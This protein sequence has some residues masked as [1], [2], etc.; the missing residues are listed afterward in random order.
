MSPARAEPAGP[1]P[2]ARA[3]ARL[4][5]DPDRLAYGLRTA[6]AACLALVAAWTLGLEHPQWAGMTV[7][8]ASQPVRAHLI[9][10]SLFRALGTVAGA[11]YGVLL[12]GLAA[13]SGGPALLVAGVALW[14]GLCAAAGNVLRGFASYG[15]L[16]AG[17]SAAMV[18]L[19]D[20]GHPEDVVGLGLDRTATVLVG[21]AVALLVGL[22]LTPRGAQADLPLRLR[23]ASAELL[24]AIAARLRAPET[25]ADATAGARLLRELA[26]LDDEIDGEGAGSLAARRE[27]R[28]RRQT[29]MA[30]VSAILWLQATPAVAADAELADAIDV[31]AADFAANAPIPQRRTSL[32]RAARRAPGELRR[33][34]AGLGSALPRGTGEPAPDRRPEPLRLHRD[35][36]AAREAA[37]RAAGTIL[38]VGAVWVATG[39]WAGPLMMLGAAILTSVFSTMEAPLSLLPRVAAG[40]ALGVAAALACR[41]LVWPHAGSEAALVLSTL[42]FVLAGGVVMGHPRLQVQAFDANMV[43]LLLLQPVW[44]LAGSLGHSLVSGVAVVSGP[45]IAMLAFRFVHPPSAARRRDALLRTLVGEVEAMASRPG[46][47]ARVTAWRARLHHRLL[48]LVRWT[49]RAGLD[50]AEAAAGGIALVRL[51][52]AVIGLEAR[53]A[54]GGLPVAER[55]ALVLALARAARVGAEPERAARDLEAVARLGGRE[56]PLFL[57][58]AEA[59]R[60]TAGLLAAAGPPST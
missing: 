31:I 14:L 39:W 56:A 21:V 10:K 48:R 49:D 27:A 4:G 35:W 22:A 29:L 12:A 51:G 44:P 16:L 58:A 55:Q 33:V 23:Q 28:H 11:I 57:A 46:A 24:A 8:A 32:A 54:E 18:A 15:A 47:R 37:V 13:R 5:L 53:L 26:A 17:Y 45:V 34:L 2:V 41:W 6:L 9:E 42:P 50:T 30:Q 60:R 38:L 19:L 25:P 40:Q 52:Q 59:V 7:W 3:A 43:L 36:I 20:A 1:D